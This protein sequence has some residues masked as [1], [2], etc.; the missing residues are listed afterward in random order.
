VGT[1]VVPVRTVPPQERGQ[2]DPSADPVGSGRSSNWSTAATGWRGHVDTIAANSRFLRF[3]PEPRAAVVHGT[4]VRPWAAQADTV[5][6]SDDDVLFGQ[7][8]NVRPG[9]NPRVGPGVCGMVTSGAFA[10]ADGTQ[11]F[12]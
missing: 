10:E 2:A 3:R 12:P 6:R 11:N 4:F 7:P 9:D 8:A 5:R 1:S